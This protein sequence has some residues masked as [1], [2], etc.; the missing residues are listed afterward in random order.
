MNEIDWFVSIMTKEDMVF[1][2][3]AMKI[4]IDGFQKNP[5]KAPLSKLEA[6][7]RDI[8]YGGSRRKRRKDSFVYPNFVNFVKDVVLKRREDIEKEDI[9]KFY[10][11]ME[12]D[13]GL[14]SFEKIALFQTLY[15][16]QYKEQFPKLVEN[17]KNKR[18]LFFGFL[19]ELDP[20]VK[21][22]S[23]VKIATPSELF[24]SEKENIHS[25][26]ATEFKKEELDYFKQIVS[27][28]TDENFSY[29]LFSRNDK[30][31]FALTFLFL[32]ENVRYKKQQYEKLVYYVYQNWRSLTI[33][34]ICEITEMQKGEVESLCKE[35]E[36]EKK[37]LRRV[38]S[39]KE[40]IEN[41]LKKRKE[42][43]TQV[44]KANEH[45]KITIE[46]LNKSIG[47]I[48]NECNQLKQQNECLQQKVDRYKE[49]ITVVQF[50]FNDCKWKVVTN[51]SRDFSLLSSLFKECIMAPQTLQ[52][53]IDKGTIGELRQYTLF[54]SRLSF[55]SS[56]LYVDLMESLRK[57]QVKTEELLSSSEIDNLKSI[58]GKLLSK[59]GEMIW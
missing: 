1:I 27:T 57:H 59:E 6:S 15:P 43:I 42:E 44:K 45:F 48:T 39:E 37:K 47:V 2:I 50:L 52:T 22:E 33:D 7:I 21:I 35:L 46:H 26:I 23:L 4:P 18:P 55:T 19:K 12:L 5:E 13:E 49:I 58:I 8:L 10:M 25:W 31:K 29:S 36:N 24:E 3:K 34:K 14:R 56:K 51:N 17:S 9:E 40:Q 16:I 30:E 32:G 28:A 11:Q 41:E 20:V 53:M 38:N 54:V